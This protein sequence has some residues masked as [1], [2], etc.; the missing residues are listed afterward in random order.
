MK[1]GFVDQTCRVPA[2]RS[3]P[4]DDRPTLGEDEAKLQ[5]Y[6]ADLADAFDA[7]A[8]HWMVRLVETRGPGLAPQ[9]AA[10]L[11]EASRVVAEQFRSLLALDIADQPIGPLELLRRA[12]RFPTD[13]LR[14]ADVPPVARDS[15]AAR[16]FPA[17]IYDLAPASFAAVD[18]SLHEPGLIWGAAKAHVHLRRRADNAL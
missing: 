3:E 10:E 12:T 6:A 5:R 9:V 8:E 16:A 13:V 11:T 14:A 1:P 18:R 17:D 2:D 4:S 7:V 15:F